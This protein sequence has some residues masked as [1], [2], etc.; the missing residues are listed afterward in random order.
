MNGFEGN[1]ISH[2]HWLSKFTIDGRVEKEAISK[3]CGPIPQL[4]EK[5]VSG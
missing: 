5:C 2:C 1:P 4:I 3:L